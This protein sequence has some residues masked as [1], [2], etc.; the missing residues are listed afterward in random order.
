MNTRLLAAGVAGGVVMF[1]WG[2]F[3][4]MILPLGDVGIGELPDEVAIAA[5]LK[6]KIPG[7]GMFYYPHSTDMAKMEQLLKERPRG[8]L[9]YTPATIP[10]S[11]GGGLATQCLNDILVGLILAWLLGSVAA[12]LPTLTSRI[13]FGIG[14]ALV[15]SL[16]YLG[17]FWNWY[18]FS[19]PFVF[20]STVDSV[21]AVILGVIVISKIG[22]RVPAR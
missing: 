11:M 22:L 2:A 1:L 9:T 16:G 20:A 4:H 3:S 19:L 14:V 15:A 13:C 7:P 21:I 6:E 17:P 12:A 18:G 8:L 5:V 10:F